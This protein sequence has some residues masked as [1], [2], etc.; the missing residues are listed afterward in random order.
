M[1][2]AFP[3]LV[4]SVHYECSVSGVYFFDVMHCCYSKHFVINVISKYE[5]KIPT[6]KFKFSLIR[7]SD[8]LMSIIV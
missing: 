3:L 7:L 4:D 1:K 5:R 6:I 8:Y 2:N